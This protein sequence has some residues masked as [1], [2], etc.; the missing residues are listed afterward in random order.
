MVLPAALLE[1]CGSTATPQQVQ[2]LL[3]LPV[4]PVSLD[5]RQARAVRAVVG[6]LIPSDATGPG[7]EEAMVWRYIDLALSR[8]LKQLKPLY[9]ANL[10]ALDALAVKRHGRAF[11]A[12]AAGRQDAILRDLE[13]GRA[14]GFTPDAATF[15]ATVLEHTREGMFGDPYWG[16]NAGFAGWDLIGFP[17]LNMVTPQ[18]YTELGAR[19]P[20]PHRSVTQFNGMF[21]VT[22]PTGRHL[23][24]SA[25][26]A[27]KDM[28]GM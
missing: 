21:M 17:G 7:A 9:T 14:D 15:F 5:A 8:D 27:A 13:A 28:G 2:S 18:A 6:R 25:A 12:L 16:G 23:G 20:L 10:A 22:L 24:P 11:A 1:A 4:K 19:P 3:G 26:M